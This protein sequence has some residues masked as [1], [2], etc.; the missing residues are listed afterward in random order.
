MLIHLFSCSIVQCAFPEMFTKKLCV[1][2]VFFESLTLIIFSIYFPRVWRKY[3]LALAYISYLQNV[4]WFLDTYLVRVYIFDKSS[5]PSIPNSNSVRPG[6]CA[7]VLIVWIDLTCTEAADANSTCDNG[8]T[9]VQD[10]DTDVCCPL[11]CGDQCGG[12]NCGTIPGVD[13][14]QCCAMAIIASGAVCSDN[15]DPPCVVDC[16]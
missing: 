7:F 6:T 13:A 11:E 14:S 4:A 10:P 12:D 16:E 2:F 3:T 1:C 15:V 8:Q 9:G 5:S